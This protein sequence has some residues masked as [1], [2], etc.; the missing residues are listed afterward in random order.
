MEILCCFNNIIDINS[1][2]FYVNQQMNTYQLSFDNWLP[3]E[4]LGMSSHWPQRWRNIVKAMPSQK[5]AT[6]FMPCCLTG[7]SNAILLHSYQ[8]TMI[9]VVYDTNRI[10]LVAST[11][12][13]KQQRSSTMTLTVTLRMKIKFCYFKPFL[14]QLKKMSMTNQDF[15][16]VLIKKLNGYF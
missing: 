7:N 1:V 5:S 16:N 3:C 9:L 13:R 4:Q 8:V 14:N 12:L 6:N 15:G 10:S 11:L 2:A